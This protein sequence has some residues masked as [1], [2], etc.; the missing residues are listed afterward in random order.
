MANRL[1]GIDT[2]SDC[3]RVAV[4][5]REKGGASILALE[6]YPGDNP[7]SALDEVA[8]R[9][10]G[11]CG[12][13]DRLASALP[14]AQGYV[15]PLDFPFQDRR[16]IRAAAT[17]ELAARIPVAI[18][19]CATALLWP[20][21]AG[22]GSAVV[23]AAVPLAA[24][25]QHLAPFE[26]AGA[27]LQIL[28][29]MPYALAGGIGSR[30]TTGILVCIGGIE[31]TLSLVEHG[32]VSDYRLI[33]GLL[34]RDEPQAVARLLRECLVMRSQ[35]PEE[36]LPVYLAGS[37]AV[38]P[39]LDGLR[40]G[41]LDAAILKLTL[42]GKEVPPAFIPA[43]ALAL[44]A[45]PRHAERSF[46]LRQGRF[47]YRGE[48]RTAR[49][50]LAAGAGLLLLSLLALGTAGFINYRERAR[51]AEA[52]QQELARMYQS[53]FPGTPLTVDVALQMASKLRE[54]RGE[55]E[56]LGLAGQPPPWRILRELSELPALAPIELEEFDFGTDE[57]RVSGSTDSFEAVNRIREQLAR[58]TLFAGAEVAESRKSLDGSRIEFRLRLPLAAGRG[59][60]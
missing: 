5:R 40:A 3:V 36:P 14:A 23:A 41:G 15:R 42:A 53:A 16:K 21:G 44:R 1:I 7:A 45:E 13:G 56:A 27:P 60:P 59:T 34:D 49:W 48:L 12:F 32:Q 30:L 55:A 35:R 22:A 8:A 33:P 28:D 11:P 37:G 6:E 47:A 18:E 2:G 57:V 39:L 4:L 9:T 20:Q 38:P 31:T 19:S 10:G 50:T 54:L 24:I 46:N 52:L 43:V 51:Q 17:L 29:L 25:D 26:A 58:S